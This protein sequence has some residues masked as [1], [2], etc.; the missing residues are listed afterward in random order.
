[1]TRA[2]PSRRPA[3]DDR[4]SVAEFSRSDRGVRAGGADMV[5]RDGLRD[6][7]DRAPRVAPG[8]QT[9]GIDR[10]VV[11]RMGP[12]T[13]LFACGGHPGPGRPSRPQPDFD[14]GALFAW[15]DTGERDRGRHRRCRDPV[16]SSLAGPYP[17]F[18]GPPCTRPSSPTCGRRLRPAPRALRLAT[19]STGGA[20]SATGS[21]SATA[22][23]PPRC[24]QA[25][26]LRLD[27]PIR[28]R[29]YCVATRRDR[30]RR[31]ER[32]A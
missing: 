13:D 31:T 14:S 1:V 17:T 3:A 10:S 5:G 24:S 22:L 28:R 20:C 19:G 2:R 25:T 9:A 11:G 4:A 15:G 29:G 21:Q 23:Q 6:R 32:D 8:D 18:R 26:A 30:R 7:P 12:S 16:P 27:G